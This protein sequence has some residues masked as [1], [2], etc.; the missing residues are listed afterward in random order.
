MKYTG[1]RVIPELMKPMN[2]LLLEHLARYHFAIHYA[3]GRVLDFACGSGFGSN[4]IAS[5]KKKEI[6]K[7]I[8]VD[9][10]RET[11]T[12]AKGKYYHPLVSFQVE[13]CVE[14]TLPEKIG[15]FD[16]IVSFETLE[17]VDKEDIFMENI[18]QMLKPGGTLVISTPFGQGR[19]KPTSEP[20]HVHQ[21]TEQEFQELFT[22][23]EEVEFYYQKGVLIEPVPGR[24][25]RHYPIGM[26][27]C[28][29]R[30]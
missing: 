4:V 20:Y 3:K 6:E 16:L 29:K 1:E 15:Q 17:H 7:I 5:A 11:I 12:Y 14:P 30:N 18:Y 19:G 26:A 9:I 21:L 24:E 23:Y 25:G 13:N 10:D 28:K 8:A 22:A 27:V 2:G